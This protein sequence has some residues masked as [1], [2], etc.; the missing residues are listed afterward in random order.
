MR[1]T[2][3]LISITRFRFYVKKAELLTLSRR[4]YAS[5]RHITLSPSLQLNLSL[6][7]LISD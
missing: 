4:P 7:A 1:I 5:D 3:S 6:L 2:F